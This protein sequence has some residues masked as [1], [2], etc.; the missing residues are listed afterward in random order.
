MELIIVIGVITV[1]IAITLPSL[2]HAKG[3]ALITVCLSNMHQLGIATDSYG[4]DN[5]NYLPWSSDQWGSGSTTWSYTIDRSSGLVCPA[6]TEF[7]DASGYDISIS[8]WTEPKYLEGVDMP[9]KQVPDFPVRLSMI[10]TPSKKIQ[11]YEW[12]PWHFSGKLW[13]SGIPENQRIR[14][15]KAGDL[16]PVSFMDDHAIRY[17]YTT[18]VNGWYPGTS[19]ACKSSG[20]GVGIS[21]IEGYQGRDVN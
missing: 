19:K 13:P 10:T 11:A 5:N 4:N 15:H 8:N 3:N 14:V 18:F 21:T 20:C 9:G 16:S 1:L 2:F 17:D 7:P 12:R 6:Q